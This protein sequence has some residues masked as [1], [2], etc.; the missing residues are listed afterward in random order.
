[1]ILSWIFLV[2][3]SLFICRVQNETNTENCIALTIVRQVFN[4]SVSVFLLSYLFCGIF[5]FNVIWC[6]FETTKTR[7]SWAVSVLPVVYTQSLPCR[8]EQRSSENIWSN[9]LLNQYFHVNLFFSVFISLLLV[10][11]DLYMEDQ[12]FMSFKW[13]CRIGNRSENLVICSEFLKGI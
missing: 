13:N 11:T 3:G 9:E 12:F 1:M 4:C 10:V 5:F 8:L 6:S 7:G 2:L